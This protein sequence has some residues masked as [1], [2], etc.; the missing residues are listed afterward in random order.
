M[1]VGHF[2]HITSDRMREN[3]FKLCQ[4]RF[5]LDIRKN[6]SSER[7]VMHWHRLPREMVEPPSPEMFRKRADG[8]WVT[9]SVGMVWMGWGWTWRSLWS[10]STLTIV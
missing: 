2:S 4:V 6:L 7:V 1:G 8:H 10:F 3:G 9:W 5:C